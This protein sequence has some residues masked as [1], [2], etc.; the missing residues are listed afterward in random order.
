M[1]GPRILLNHDGWRGGNTT[2]G[3]D[4][5]GYKGGRKR[6]YPEGTAL[7]PV[8][9]KMAE[10]ECAMAIFLGRGNMSDG[11]RRA[12][13][14]AYKVAHQGQG[15]LP[16]DLAALNRFEMADR[17]AAE[18]RNKRFVKTDARAKA[19]AGTIS[20]ESKRLADAAATD[21]DDITS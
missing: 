19:A 16:A 14:T 21:W 6:L 11:I 5:K 10:P 3:P 18:K 1:G 4:R 7:Y 15:V 12:L 2:R 20:A 17:I 9:L 13:E 8:A